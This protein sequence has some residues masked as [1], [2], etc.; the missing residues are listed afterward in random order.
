[1]TDSIEFERRDSTAWITFNRPNAKNALTAEMMDDLLGVLDGLAD[2]SEVRVVVISGKGSDFC[3]GADV[4]AMATMLKLSP[5]ERAARFHRTIDERIVP[6]LHAFRR[7]SQPV[8][9]SVRG[10][11][12]G[13]GVQFALLSDLVVASETAQFVLPQVRLAHTLDHGESWLLPRRIGLSKAMQLCLLGE[14]MNAVDAERFGL[15]NWI[16]TDEA[17]ERETAKLV[18]KLLRGAPD[19]LRRTKA[20]LSDSANNNLEMQM[21]AER[22]HVGFGAASNNF[23]EAVRAFN[24]K[25]APKFSGL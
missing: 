13:I 14:P 15:T 7:L 5:E 1:M 11:V 8:V 17:L 23:I 6:L 10:Y 25:R 3:S 18:A 2:D 9:A 4:S 12:I 22:T 19:A 24:E 21:E 16:T 20:L